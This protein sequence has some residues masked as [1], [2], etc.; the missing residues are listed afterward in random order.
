MGQNQMQSQFGYSPEHYLKGRVPLPPSVLSKPS[1]FFAYNGQVT[2]AA[3]AVGTIYIQIDDDSHFLVETLQAQSGLQSGAQDAATAI[4]TDTTISRSWSSLPVPFRDLFG[5]GPAP[6]YLGDPNL[7]RPT[8]TI[9]IQITSN[10]ATT[11]TFYVSLG[12]RRIYNLEKAEVDFMT[13]R[14]WYQY[15]MNVP[16]LAASAV[17]VRADVQVYN[18]SDFY[19]K[20]LLSSQLAD[21]VIGAAAGSES[22]E[23][24]VNFKDTTTDQSLFNTPTSARLVTGYHAAKLD[25]SIDYSWGQ[26]YSLRKPWLIRR[27]GKVSGYFNN[28]ST[29]PISN[30]FNLIL[31]GIRVFDAP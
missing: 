1:R 26:P 21:A 8:S 29:D 3:G 7:L 15:V 13:R 23:V 19:V 12:G 25:S 28:N 27:N 4:I 24:M 10:L 16:V 22:S 18:E 5:M 11:Q 20:R 14:L 30:G 2:I 9:T 17:N 6:K 31:E